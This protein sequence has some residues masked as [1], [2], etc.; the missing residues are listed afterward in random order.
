MSG[1]S[2]P[3]AGHV[4]VSYLHEDGDK[5]DPLVEELRKGG[6]D[7]WRD[8]DNLH[9]GVRWESAIRRAIESGVAFIA[10]FSESFDARGRS[11]M[12]E[13]LTLAIDE[14]RKRPYDR[15][16][17]IPVLLDPVAVPDWDIGA[18]DTLSKLH[19]VRLFADWDGEVKRLLQAIG[20]QAGDAPE[21]P[22]ASPQ[23][24]P[25]L[26]REF[27]RPVSAEYLSRQELFDSF[28]DAALY[29]SSRS[30]SD[31]IHRSLGVDK[32]I[33]A[34]S[35]YSAPSAA[36]SW[37]RWCEDPTNF[38]YRDAVDFW[39]GSSGG[40][41]AGSIVTRLGRKDFAYV[42]MGPGDGRKDA[43]LAGHWLGQGA[44]ITYYP[45]DVNLS[46]LQGAIKHVVNDSLGATVDRLY[47]KG[48][49]ADFDR[50]DLLEMV[51]AQHSGPKV[52]GLFGQSFMGF[53]ER[54]QLLRQVRLTMSGD[55]LLVLE[56]PLT[57][58]GDHVGQI[59][60]GTELPFYFGPL[61]SLGV[62]FDPRLA[63]VRTRQKISWIPGTITSEVRYEEAAIDGHTY[64]DVT[65]ARV[66]R[67]TEKGLLDALARS[68]F[69]VLSAQL[70]G[71]RDPSLVCVA[72][73]S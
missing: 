63:S 68:G 32:A 54:P 59:D 62:P 38:G 47:V 24:S 5:V 12:Y 33:P 7:V 15:V 43:A 9:P 8:R 58:G 51:F 60:T 73:L 52:V 14:L 2:N 57:T 37:I 27:K 29:T 61:R 49:L 25:G 48:V 26:Q 46:L 17:F 56:V 4:F 23:S 66:H 55:D 36:E 13:E 21:A 10:C 16:W 39:T 69:V 64:R 71:R 67:Y 11:Y 3:A 41:V 53:D 6:V 40:E 34:R 19:Q 31:E 45:Y 44:D 70:A 72:C 20:P 35:L 50:T 22:S 30:A 65:L 28:V 1:K 18:G 42:S